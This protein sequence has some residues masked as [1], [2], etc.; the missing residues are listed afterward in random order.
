MYVCKSKVKVAAGKFLNVG[1]E[2]KG[3]DAE[4]LCELGVLEKKGAKKPKK[5]KDEAETLPE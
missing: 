3:D 4:R 5:K 1:D 2:Y